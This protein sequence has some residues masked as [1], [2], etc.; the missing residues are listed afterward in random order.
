MSRATRKDMSCVTRK[1]MSR[2]PR[3]DISRDVTGR[4]ID[5]PRLLAKT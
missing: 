5:S 1:D 4:A 3:N 2:V